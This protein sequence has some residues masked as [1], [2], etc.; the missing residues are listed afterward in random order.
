MTTSNRFANRLFLVVAGLLTLL[1]GAAIVVVALPG[2]GFARDAVRSAR[3]A[4]SSALSNTHLSGGGMAGTG[5]YLPWLLAI[6]CLIIV[7]IGIVAASTRGR[8]RIDRVVESD[9]ASGN[10]VVSSRFAETALVDALSSRRDVS[11][12]S[13]AAYELKG[14][15][16]LKVKLRVT[17]GSSPTAAV[18][19]AS[20][21][22][23]G[24][25][26][27]LGT[28]RPLPVLVEVT[29]ASPTRPGADSRV[30]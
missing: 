22:V 15:P 1:V 16:A 28:G 14:A 20:V 8:G 9:D 29:G 7:I 13:V 10:I 25:D 6:L 26:L 11:S 4:Q 19:A 30:R 3:D 18:E 21:A 5:S 12:V 27:V 17:A 23:R 24:L 2:G